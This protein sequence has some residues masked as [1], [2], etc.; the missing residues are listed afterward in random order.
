M[1]IYSVST[2]LVRRTTLQKLV[3]ISLKRTFENCILIKE[4][5]KRKKNLLSI[6]KNLHQKSLYGNKN[7]AE[8]INLLPKILKKNLQ[9]RLQVETVLRK[10]QVYLLTIFTH[11][12]K[13]YLWHGREPD[14]T[15]SYETIFGSKD[16]ILCINLQAKFTITF[17]FLFFL[18]HNRTFINLGKS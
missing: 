4:L 18:L 11:K 14:P 6:C 10:E 5:L 9:V 7:V 16:I 1:L 12:Q 2:L 3:S 8:K 15:R 17:Y 13:N